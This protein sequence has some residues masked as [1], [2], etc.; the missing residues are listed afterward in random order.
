[1]NCMRWFTSY[2]VIARSFT[3]RRGRKQVFLRGGNRVP[4]T[5]ISAAEIRV[6]RRDHQGHSLRQ[7]WSCCS[8][9]WARCG[10]L[11]C[12]SHWRHTRAGPAA[13]AAAKSQQSDRKAEIRCRLYTSRG[14]EAT[15]EGKINLQ[16]LVTELQ[17]QTRAGGT[18]RDEIVAATCLG[19]SS[20]QSGHS[21][22]RDTALTW[23]WCGSRWCR[24]PSRH[25]W[26]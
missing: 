12:R 15:R 17:P 3:M 6:L 9:R 5:I 19:S 23:R 16:T 1:M 14:S 20:C 25:S 10:N 8:V 2:W 24:P 7:V 22:R 21:A 13:V 18:V 26:N 4:I 11:R